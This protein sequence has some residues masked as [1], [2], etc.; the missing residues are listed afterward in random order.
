MFGKKNDLEEVRNPYI[1]TRKVLDDLKA[2]TKK[3]STYQ[4]SYGN[5]KARSDFERGVAMGRLKQLCEQAEYY[6]KYV[7]KSNDVTI[8]K[9]QTQGF[10]KL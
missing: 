2:K 3:G 10:E 6:N 1:A 4:D 9:Y 8:S 5:V 7:K